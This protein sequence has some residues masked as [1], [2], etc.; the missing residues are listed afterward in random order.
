HSMSD[1]HKYRTKEEV[2][3]YKK[4]DPIEVVRGTILERKYATEKELDAIV[5]KINAQVED[6]VKFAEE[7]NFPDPKEAMKD[8]YVQQD[9]P[10][11][12]D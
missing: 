11:A 3:E 5:E 2:D 12:I 7:S 10:F 1:P 6:S 4:R 8:I 9:Y